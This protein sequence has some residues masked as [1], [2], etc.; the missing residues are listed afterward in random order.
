METYAIVSYQCL[1]ILIHRL[2]IMKE[3]KYTCLLA[4]QAEAIE[5]FSITHSY[6]INSKRL[7]KDTIMGAIKKIMLYMDSLLLLSTT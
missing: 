2:I 6:L 3:W 7:F 4:H 5:M 1:L